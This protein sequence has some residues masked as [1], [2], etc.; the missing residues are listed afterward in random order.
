MTRKDEKAE[1]LLRILTEYSKAGSSILERTFTL[2]LVCLTAA[3][4]KYTGHDGRR[5]SETQS[6]YAF[7][8]NMQV[9]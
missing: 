8:R 7:A 5:E 4:G 3:L 2:W 1:W 9:F 6:I